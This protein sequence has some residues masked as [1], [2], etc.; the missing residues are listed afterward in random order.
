MPAAGIDHYDEGVYA[1]SALGLADGSQPHRLYPQQ[2]RFS[3][4]VYPALVSLSFRIFGPSDQSAIVVNIVLGALSVLALWWVARIWFGAAAGLAAAA[5][6][7]LSQYHIA[8]SRSAL[9]DVAFGLFFILAL[10]TATIAFRRQ[11]FGLA[12]LSG[13][14]VGLAWNT[15]YH[16][17]FLLIIVMLAQLPFLW[18]ERRRPADRLRRAGL[19]AAMGVTAVFCALPWFLYVQGE[20]GGY[21]GLLRYQ[22]SLI[23]G[24]WL[25]NLIVQ[26][27]FQYFLEGP[28]SKISVIVAFSLALFITEQ[29]T[30]RPR[31]RFP[32][33]SLVLLLVLSLA[34]L[35]AGATAVICILS[36]VAA[37]LILWRL[38]SRREADFGAAWIFISW[39]SILFVASPLYRPYA[40]L[41]LPLLMALFIGA[42]YS[43][44]LLAQRMTVSERA[45]VAVA[46]YVFGAVLSIA[47]VLGVALALTTPS[48]PWRRARSMADAAD[49]MTHVI[50]PSTPVSVVGEPDLAFYLHLAGRPAFE[51]RDNPADWQTPGEPTYL[52]AGVY[53]RR[54]P[55]LR[56]SLSALGS[57]LELVATYKAYPKDLRLLDDFTTQEAEQFLASPDATYDL[58][59]YRILPKPPSD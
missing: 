32:W 48:N 4:L 40:R 37:P 52:V 1:F 50:P 51:R 9:T 20:S 42:G 5:C 54:A 13:L 39:L 8:L 23:D 27:Q 21:L 59:L 19:I 10:G 15:K 16:G 55:Q 25:P 41:A 35:V 28:L 46:W 22:S 24:R 58:N 2:S 6:L 17:W 57:S 30:G 14:F 53:S 47:A 3:P 38:Y 56:E 36:V 11:C 12:I 7:A 49:A 26:M 44:S 33:T 34:V 18:S 31:T 45:S 43:F 29:Q